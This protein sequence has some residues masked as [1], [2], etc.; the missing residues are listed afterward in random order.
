MAVIF[1]IAGLVYFIIAIAA[2]EPAL[3]ILAGFFLGLALVCLNVGK[4]LDRKWLIWKLDIFRVCKDIFRVYKEMRLK[5]SAYELKKAIY[6]NEVYQ[7]KIQSNQSKSSNNQ[8]YDPNQHDPNK[9]QGIGYPGLLN[10]GF[11][12]SI[13]DAQSGGFSSNAPSMQFVNRTGIASGAAGSRAINGQPENGIAS[14]DT[15]G[16]DNREKTERKSLAG[17]I[18]REIKKFAVESQPRPKQQQ[19][20]RR[21]Q[22]PRQ[23]HQ[24]RR[25]YQPRR[26]QSYRHSSTSRTYSGRYEG[27]GSTSYAR[28]SRPVRRRRNSYGDYG[29]GD[30]ENYEDRYGKDDW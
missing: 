5:K 8:Q 17:R 18:W 9:I 28:P 26:Q 27:R 11:L 22:S 16:A 25:Q 3:T 15:N 4:R 14:G 30:Y 24:P 21:S 7:S 29:Y 13:N 19:T 20:T 12:E 6:E 23:Y 1:F 2:V 10:T